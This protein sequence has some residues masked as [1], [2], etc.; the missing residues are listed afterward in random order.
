MP[1]PIEK[2]LVVG[3]SSR[4]LFDLQT[5][6]EIF[7]KQGL[8][9]YKEFQNDNRTVV[10]EKGLAYPFIRRFLN[11]N[12]L[13][14]DEQPVEVVVLSNNSPE[15]GLRIFNSIREYKLDISRAAF[16]SGRS[17]YEYIPAFNISLFLSTDENDVKNAISKSYPAGRILKT[18]IHDDEEDK[19]LRL[20]FDFD[21][22][23]ADDSAEQYYQECGD[24]DKYYEHETAY[25]SKP[26][27]AGLLLGFFQRVSF[28]QELEDK[29]L[30]KDPQYKKVLRTAIITARNAPAH[31]RAVN[32]LK[33]W[34]VNVDEMFFLGGIEKRRILNILKP[35][36]YERGRCL[37]KNMTRRSM[38]RVYPTVHRFFYT[39]T[40]NKEI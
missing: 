33:H 16:T 30:E 27:E 7:K 40:A 10:L 23:L 39:I 19:E 38:T 36:L 15:T 35:L 9:A 22:V 18:T 28:F 24:L 37:P 13:F 20:A 8:K 14:P 3:V 6:D 21:G 25:S 31:E 1:Y 11:I 26:L 2:K 5:E 32:T 17:P 34:G 29:I 12:K 4:A